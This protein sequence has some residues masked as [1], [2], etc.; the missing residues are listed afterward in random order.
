MNDFLK[1]KIGND[2][3]NYFDLLENNL[4]D[5]NVLEDKL[6]IIKNNLIIIKENDL[7]GFFE[8]EINKLNY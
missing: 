8:K 4:R 5:E 6:N 2:F 3:E 7:M 1:V